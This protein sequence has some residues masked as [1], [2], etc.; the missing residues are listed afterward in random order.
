MPKAPR[1]TKSSARRYF[2]L[3]VSFDNGPHEVTFPVH[4][5][6]AQEDGTRTLEE[7]ETLP[8]ANIE[9]IHPQSSGDGQLSAG[10]PA[11]LSI[12]SSG[13]GGDEG[14]RDFDDIDLV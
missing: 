5:F 4:S 1:K 10:P 13:S 12:G 9:R 14:A 8:S 3:R 2:S 11:A 6:P 7:R